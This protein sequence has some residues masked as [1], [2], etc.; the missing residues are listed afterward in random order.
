M[1]KGPAIIAKKIAHDSRAHSIRSACVKEVEHLIHDNAILEHVVQPVKAKT[2]QQIHMLAERAVEEHAKGI[3]IQPVDYF[4]PLQANLCHCPCFHSCFRSDQHVAQS[5]ELGVR[6][7]AEG[8][9]IMAA[10]L[11]VTS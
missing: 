4:Q 3:G 2:S 6:V 9:M 5:V 8:G 1:E 11:D 7:R 10:Y